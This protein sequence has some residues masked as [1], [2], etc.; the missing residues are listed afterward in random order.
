[1][2]DLIQKEG[3]N[4]KLEPWD[5]WFYSEKV[6][7]EKYDFSEENMRPFLSLENIRQ[8]AFKTAERLFDIKFIIS[9]ILK[10]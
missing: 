6:R 2:Q 10:Y 7:K 3:N 5:W 8:A 1:M 4:F 9:F